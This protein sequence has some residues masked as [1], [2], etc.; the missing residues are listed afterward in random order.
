[1]DPAYTVY[2]PY[3]HACQD[4]LSQDNREVHL[5]TRGED[6]AGGV[7][8]RHWGDR[9]ATGASAGWVDATRG[10]AAGLSVRAAFPVRFLTFSRYRA[11]I[12]FTRSWSLSNSSS[13]S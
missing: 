1:M 13:I 7:S 9:P 5:H 4:S 12:F 10:T 8:H 3:T 11:A 2:T 6:L